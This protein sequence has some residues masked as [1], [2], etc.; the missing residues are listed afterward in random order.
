[1]GSNT[2]GL[3]DLR[4]VVKAKT[5]QTVGK[6]PEWA[7]CEYFYNQPS[8]NNWVAVKEVILSYNVGETLLFTIYSHYG[9]LI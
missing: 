7:T 1:M 6:F 3:E 8:L 4:D 9:N 5:V 2:Y